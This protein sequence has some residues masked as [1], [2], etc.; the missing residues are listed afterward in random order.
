[1][2]CGLL[3]RLAGSVCC[4]CL[5]LSGA[6][7]PGWAQQAL[8]PRAQEAVNLLQYGDRDEQRLALLRLEALREPAVGDI[9]ADYLHYK[10]EGVRAYA[11]RTWIALYGQAVLSDLLEAYPR[12]KSVRVRRSILLALEPYRA[13]DARIAELYYAALIDRKTEMRITAVDL[14]SRI[15]EPRAHEAIRRRA[16]KEWRRDVRRVLKLALARIGAE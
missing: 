6:T 10:D 4:V 13:V 2:R 1:M 9:V 15:D 7:T 14:V 8:S 3:Y 11:Y 12:E 16:K 5:M